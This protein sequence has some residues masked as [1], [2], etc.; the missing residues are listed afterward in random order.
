MKEILKR[1]QI[2]V[3]KL[4]AINGAFF[5]CATIAFFMG[6]IPWYGWIICSGA[7]LTYRA[8]QKIKELI[9]SIKGLNEDV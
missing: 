4:F 9:S 3:I 5:I 6:L 1:L 7:V 2:L 8:V